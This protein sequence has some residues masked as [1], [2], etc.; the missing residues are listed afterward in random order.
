MKLV[1][2]TF[3]ETTPS[4]IKIRQTRENHQARWMPKRISFLK[5]FLS[6]LKFKVIKTEKNAIDRIYT[7][8]IKI[9][10][11]SWF[12]ATNIS[13]VDLNVLCMNI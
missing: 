9:Y 3:G 11:K 6:R 13:E 10:I 1:I 2:I 5:I 4:E 7:F 8:V 12:T